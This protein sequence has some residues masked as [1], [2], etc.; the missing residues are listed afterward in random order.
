M[1]ASGNIA[2]TLESARF[3]V[4]PMALSGTLTISGG[5]AVGSALTVQANLNAPG[6]YTFQ[7][8]NDA[9]DIPGAVGNT[10]TIQS[11]DLG[12]NLYVRASM[13][14]AAD[15]AYTGNVSSGAFAVPALPPA[16][17]VID[18]ASDT[19]SISV[20]WNTPASNGA[21]ITGYYLIVTPQGGSGLSYPVDAG[22]NNYTVN[23][24]NAG[25]T[26]TVY[27]RAVNSYGSTSSSVVT[28]AVQAAY[29]GSTPDAPTRESRST[30][31]V[32]LKKI[33]G[34]EYSMDGK[35]WQSSNVFSGL[36]EG[37]KYSFYQRVA[38]TATTA[39][40]PASPKY[41]C[42][43]LS[44]SDEDDDDSSSSS[45]GSSSS[46]SSSS[47]STATESEPLHEL[48]LT[49]STSNV[50]FSTMNRLVAGNKEK[51][52]TIS[53]PN[54]RYSFGK[55]TMQAESGRVWYDFGLSVNNCIH[56]NAVKALAGDWHVATV[57]FNY[58]GTLPAQATISIQLGT[59]YAGQKLYYYK[60]D[61]AG[62]ALS[63][64]QTTTVDASGWASV[65][66]SQCSDYVFTSG[67]VTT[68]FATP[69]P[70]PTLSPTPVAGDVPL[71]GP[72]QP[73]K[74]GSDWILIGIIALAALLLIAIIW[75]WLRR[76]D[77]SS[78]LDDEDFYEEEYEEYGDADEDNEYDDEDGR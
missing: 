64:I 78:L 67:D 21:P 33:S 15:A 31:R 30:S 41:S 72:V 50:L 20:S 44:S 36:K 63:F 62:N 23:G 74:K 51:D 17:P 43:T 4:L 71:A 53:F 25:T 24:L 57:H 39:A 48:T 13:T 37:T 54:V 65:T 76:S 69:T 77:E 3:R 16:V 70:T 35:T 12:T 5:T 8:Y 66:Q 2:G 27:L 34:Y 7:W 32:T 75:L 61:E 10:Y 40:S 1:T 55:G 58:G 49:G 56:N 28:V 73:V 47:G 38:E 14:P 45:S 60:Y 22:A 26:Y 52:V 46:G 68:A 18:V 9:G 6:N 42:Y 19:G 11:S 29:T 59:Q